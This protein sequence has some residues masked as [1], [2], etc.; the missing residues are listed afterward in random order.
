MMSRTEVITNPSDGLC[1]GLDRLPGIVSEL[2][3]DVVDT[4]GVFEGDGERRSGGPDSL[5]CVS[6]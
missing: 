3:K 2:A 5:L 6:V 4:F 1:S